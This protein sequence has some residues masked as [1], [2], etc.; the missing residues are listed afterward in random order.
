MNF[1]NFFRNVH[2]S[3]KLKDL[4]KEKKISLIF[5]KSKEQLKKRF[6]QKIKGS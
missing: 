3:K 6:P 4:L 1:G 2:H 5:T